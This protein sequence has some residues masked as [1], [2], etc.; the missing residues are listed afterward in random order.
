MASYHQRRPN[1]EPSWRARSPVAPATRPWHGFK[2]S[3][4]PLVVTRNDGKIHKIHHAVKGKLT[5]IRHDL[6]GSHSFSILQG[7]TRPH[8]ATFVRDSSKTVTQVVPPGDWHQFSPEIRI[9]CR[10]LQGNHGSFF[11]VEGQDQHQRRSLRQLMGCLCHATLYQLGGV[12]S[13][14]TSHNGGPETIDLL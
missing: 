2:M 11:P 8:S 4:D 7:S 13:T 1:T 3:G 12:A 14:Q 10:C 9:L 5:D 6:I